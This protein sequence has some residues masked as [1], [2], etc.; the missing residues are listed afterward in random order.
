MTVQWECYRYHTANVN[1][2]DEHGQII[3]PAAQV[4]DWRHEAYER[5][6]V[7]TLRDF[8]EALGWLEHALGEAGEYITDLAPHQAIRVPQL[9]REATAGLAGRDVAYQWRGELPDRHRL[10]LVVLGRYETGPKPAA[11]RPRP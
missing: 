6:R 3:H 10:I 9:M 2:L 1:I 5:F 8:R 7:A 4:R 11:R